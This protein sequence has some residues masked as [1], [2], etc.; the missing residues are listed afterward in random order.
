M[1][2]SYR[3]RTEAIGK[4]RKYSNTYSTKKNEDREQKRKERKMPEKC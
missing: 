2:Q 1:A 3:T 4:A